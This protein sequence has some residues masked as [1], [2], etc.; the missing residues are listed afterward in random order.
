MSKSIDHTG[1]KAA[2][3]FRKLRQKERKQMRKTPG[4]S[5]RVLAWKRQDGRKPSLDNDHDFMENHEPITL[6][7]QGVFD[8]LV[9][10][11]WLHLEAMDDRSW[12]LSVGERAFWIDIPKDPKQPAQITGEEVRPDTLFGDE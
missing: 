10:D 5:W 8:E 12:F 11:D 1:E 7:D 9:I 4:A 2:A 3:K 6:E